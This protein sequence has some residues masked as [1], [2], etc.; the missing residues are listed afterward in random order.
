L[1]LI[2]AFSTAKET[3]LEQLVSWLGSVINSI[4]CSFRGP[5]F[6]SHPLLEASHHLDSYS[7]TCT[8]TNILR[9]KTKLKT[10]SFS[11]DR[12]SITNVWELQSEA[13]CFRS[14]Q[15]KVPENE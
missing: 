13:S 10:T 8:E 14:N 4:H 2:I 6:T 11:E 1:L 15:Q 5:T 9:N 12:L 3:Q 7:Y